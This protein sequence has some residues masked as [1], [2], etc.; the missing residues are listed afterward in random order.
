MA[1]SFIP[2]KDADFLAFGSNYSTLISAQPLLYSL[3][4]PIATLLATKQAAYAAAYAMAV[5]PTTRGGA[6]VLGKDLSRRDLEGYIR[7]TARTVQG[8]PGVTAAQRF[9]L[10]LTVRGSGSKPVPAPATAPSLDIISAV[11][12]TVK[13]RLHDAASPGRRGKLPGAAGA[14]ASAPP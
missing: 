13:I 9:A 1:R 5:D 11:G 10:G 6:A 7:L 2:A 14:S 12:R 4:V 3:T 8:A